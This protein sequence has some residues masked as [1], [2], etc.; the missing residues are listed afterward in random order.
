MKGKPDLISDA[1]GHAKAD[2]RKSA[3]EKPQAGE[4]SHEVSLMTPKHCRGHRFCSTCESQRVWRIL[5]WAQSSTE[6]TEIGV[7]GR[8]EQGLF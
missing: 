8:R 7:T 5:I 1:W 2:T 3:L 6:K 4:P